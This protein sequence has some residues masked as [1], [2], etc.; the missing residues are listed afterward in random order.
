[1]LKGYKPFQLLVITLGIAA[2]S[3]L[4]PFD[5]SLDFAGIKHNIKYFL[6]A[7]LGFPDV[8]KDELSVGF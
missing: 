7:Q 6:N 4:Q 2:A 5:F 1:M 3:Y 8:L